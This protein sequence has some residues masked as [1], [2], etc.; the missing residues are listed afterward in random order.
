MN[1]IPLGYNP[2]KCQFLADLGHKPP[3][4]NCRSK[5]CKNCNGL[6]YLSS[7]YYANSICYTCV[8]KEGLPVMCT[9][10]YSTFTICPIH[11]PVTGL[12]TINMCFPEDKERF[13]N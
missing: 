1:N 6:A 11:P 12:T 4:Y 10:N 13:K 9:D 2:C 3:C 5:I 7:P 8:F